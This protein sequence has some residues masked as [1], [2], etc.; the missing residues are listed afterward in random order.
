M[1][2]PQGTRQIEAC[3]RT[4]DPFTRHM[5]FGECRCNIDRRALRPLA[6]HGG[7]SNGLL[8]CRRAH[9]DL[10]AYSETRPPAYADL[11]RTGVCRSC[12]VRL[13]CGCANM[14]NRNGFDSVANTVDIEPDF[15]ADG[16]IGEGGHLYVG[17][18]GRR[19]RRE[20]GLCARFTDRGYR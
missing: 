9:H 2:E 7:Y 17:G 20:I 16:D 4:D 8:A 13:D 6:T 3:A 10:V 18:S 19:I 14:G 15:V 12:E 5:R 1:M 11:G